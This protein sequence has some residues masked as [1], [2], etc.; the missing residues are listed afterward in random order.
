MDPFLK[1]KV[2]IVVDNTDVQG[3][4]VVIETNPTYYNMFGRI[5]R[6]THIGTLQTDFTTI[7][8][9]SYLKA[10][11]GFLVVNAHDI[12]LNFGVWETLKRTVKNK[13]VRIEDL[14]E[15]FGVVPVAAMRPSPIP[16]YVK[17]IMIGNQMIYH[18]LYEMDEDFRKIFKVKADFDS[19]MERDSKSLQSYAVVHQQPLPSTKICSTSSRRASPRSSNTAR[20]SS[21]TR[22]SSPPASATSPTSCARPVTGR[23][24]ECKSVSA[25][26]VRPGRGREVLPVEPGR[27]ADSAR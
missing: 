21:T 5:D 19:E 26:H 17:V 20:A 12:L 1:Y 9:G 10:N 16:A 27:G 15:Q 18:L 4:P 7:Q 22:R 3:A 14:S 25:C 11:G 13:E 8:A 2:N 24:G 6:W 23:A